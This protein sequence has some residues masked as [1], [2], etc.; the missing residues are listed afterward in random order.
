MREHA[1][2]RLRLR[3]TGQWPGL[4]PKDRARSA[5]CGSSEPDSV[6]NSATRSPPS[7]SSSGHDK[8]C[9]AIKVSEFECRQTKAVRQEPDLD[10]EVSNGLASRAPGDSPHAKVSSTS[11]LRP[12]VALEKCIIKARLDSEPRAVGCTGGAVV[13]AA[14]HAIRSERPLMEQMDHNPLVRGAAAQCAD[15]GRDRVHQERRSASGRRRGATTRAPRPS[16]PTPVA[17]PY[18]SDDGLDLGLS[19]SFFLSLLIVRMTKEWL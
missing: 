7:A 8:R 6:C 16:T 2:Q 9:R 12:C 13:G 15:L 18:R 11:Q 4:H 1:A 17:K 5:S 10:Y 14:F 19:R 3:G